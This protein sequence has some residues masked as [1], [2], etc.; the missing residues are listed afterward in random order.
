MIKQMKRR[1]E[2]LETCR[3]ESPRVAEMRRRLHTMSDEERAHLT[4]CLADGRTKDVPP[5]F[6]LR[7]LTVE[8]L[9]AYLGASL[10]SVDWGAPKREC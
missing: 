2:M 9:E 3:F 8:E 6:D 5:L 4:Q 7:T 1:I 10:V